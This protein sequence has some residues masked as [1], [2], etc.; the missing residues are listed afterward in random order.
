MFN[1]NPLD[2]STAIIEILVLL[3]VAAA[4][5]F[6]TAW[7]YWRRRYREMESQL[8]AEIDGLRNTWTNPEDAQK[9]RDDLDAANK[10]GDQ[11]K[12]E[13]NRK[14]IEIERLSRVVRDKEGELRRVNADLS[15]VR[16][17]LTATQ[18]TLQTTRDARDRLDGE[19]EQARLTIEELQ[20]YLQDHKAEIATLKAAAAASKKGK[21]KKSGTRTA[22]QQAQLEAVA[23]QRGTINF[24]RIGTATADVADD[25]KK[26]K[27]IGPFI[28]A[29]LNA[30]G[31]FTFAQISRF[32]DE[33]V[34]AVTKAIK[35]FPGR[36]KRDNWAAQSQKIDQRDP[37]GGSE[38][39]GG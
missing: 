29:K 15:T 14:Q 20:K 2:K 38:G 26:I 33:D 39:G 13:L 21:A 32:T 18:A 30:L 25:L 28:E 24:G 6:I 9:L 4:I 19:L 7:I 34:E 10:L 27:G 31:I 16:G 11:L 35:F 12:V 1:L 22:K 23:A 17:E 36:I 5:G 3:L 37:K 8:Q